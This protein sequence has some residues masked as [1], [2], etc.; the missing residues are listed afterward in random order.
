MESNVKALKLLRAISIAIATLFCST[1]A[2]AQPVSY[3]ATFSPDPPGAFTTIGSLGQL[4]DGSFTPLGSSNGFAAAGK[5]AGTL[6]FTFTGDWNLSNFTL[7]NNINTTSGGVTAFALRF[8]DSA[9]TL[10]GTET[11]AGVSRLPPPTTF[12]LSF[13]G[14]HRV[15]MQITSSDAQIEIREVQFAGV[16]TPPP[17]PPPP[18]S[19]CCPPS[20]SFP[21]PTMFNSVQG[22]VANSYHLNFTLNATLDAQMTAYVSLLKALDSSV[23]SM[24]MVVNAY[25]GGL[26]TGAPVISGPALQTGIVFWVPPPGPTTNLWPLSAFFTSTADL[27]SNTWTVVE[28]TIWIGRRG[29]FVQSCETRRFAFSPTVI[30]LRRRG[31]SSPSGFVDYTGP[32]PRTARPPASAPPTR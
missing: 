31:G 23:T 27:P 20:A 24:A 13:A 26:V 10:L 5:I 19:T 15:E 3:T 2:L 30:E 12:P 18:P 22:N 8:Y 17:P 9:G 6:T 25:N 4:N 7:W 1:V 28:V 14:V 16:R 29:E 21:I 32:A 11:R